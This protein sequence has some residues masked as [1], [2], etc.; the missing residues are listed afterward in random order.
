MMGDDEG[1]QEGVDPSKGKTLFQNSFEASRHFFSFLFLPLSPFP[2]SPFTLPLLY[3]A[4][5]PTPQISLVHRKDTRIIPIHILNII[6]EGAINQEISHY[7]KF[8]KNVF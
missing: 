6:L 4:L 7:I 5:L 2:S 3:L 8:I 1:E